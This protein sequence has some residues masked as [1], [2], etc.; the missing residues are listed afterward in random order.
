MQAGIQLPH[1]QPEKSDIVT[2]CEDSLVACGVLDHPLS[3][4]SFKFIN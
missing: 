4:A 3:L 1:F 2:I